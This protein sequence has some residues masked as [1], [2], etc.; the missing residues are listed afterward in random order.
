MLLWILLNQVGM[1]TK[2]YGDGVYAIQTFPSQRQPSRLCI[3]RN[4]R[5][6]V[7]GQWWF[8]Q[9]EFFDGVANFMAQRIEGC[10][11]VLH[12]KNDNK[13]IN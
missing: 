5:V 13:S 2:M 10:V 6:H 8:R 9:S 4:G 11:D 12:Q 7:G 3:I 1:G